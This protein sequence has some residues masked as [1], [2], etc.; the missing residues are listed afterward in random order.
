MMI[1]G[2]NYYLVKFCSKYAPALLKSII[3]PILSHFPLAKIFKLVQYAPLI[4]L[5]LK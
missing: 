5:Q 1:C 3:L 2:P 4:E